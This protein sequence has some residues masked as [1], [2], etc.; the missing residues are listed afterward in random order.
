M[1]S[2]GKIFSG[3]EATKIAKEMGEPVFNITFYKKDDMVGVHVEGKNEEATAELLM[4]GLK[5]VCSS[6]GLICVP[7]E[8]I[9]IITEVVNAIRKKASTNEDSHETSATS[10]NGELYS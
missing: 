4:E 8:E 6:M 2:E 5:N 3:E 7:A 10:E 9:C 1:T